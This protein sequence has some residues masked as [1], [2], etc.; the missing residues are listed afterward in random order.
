MRLCADLGVV[1]KQIQIQQNTAKNMIEQH[2]SPSCSSMR[3]NPYSC[4]LY[5]FFSVNFLSGIKTVT[6]RWSEQITCTMG[7]R[8]YCDYCDR[9]FQDNMHNRKK[10]LNGVQ[11]HRAKKAWFDHF[12]GETF[13]L[14]TFE[15]WQQFR[16]KYVLQRMSCH[17]VFCFCVKLLD[18][19]T[20]TYQF[21]FIRLLVN[22]DWGM[23]S[24]HLSSWLHG[25]TA[26]H[27]GRNII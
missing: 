23:K 14:K 21:K 15:E 11:H 3:I 9:S 25:C 24:S 13:V 19:S 12:R 16:S 2:H 17:V 8:Y 22:C 20:C 5:I 10:H 18:D 26:Y 7:R 27:L 1:S 4:H 6:S